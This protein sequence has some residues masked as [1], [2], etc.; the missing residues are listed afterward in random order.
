MLRHEFVIHRFTNG[1]YLPITCCDVCR[2]ASVLVVLLTI[3]HIN[4]YNNKTRKI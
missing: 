3:I 1:D 2:G 4:G